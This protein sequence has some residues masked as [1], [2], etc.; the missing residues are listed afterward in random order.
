MPLRVRLALSNPTFM[1]S[2]KPMGEAA[3]ISETLATRSII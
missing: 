1:A 3:I 2:S